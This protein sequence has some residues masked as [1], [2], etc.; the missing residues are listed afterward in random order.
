VSGESV[1]NRG[2]T[3]AQRV[4]RGPHVVF[5]FIADWWSTRYWRSL[6]WSVPALL[7][8]L[9]I[10]FGGWT[11]GRSSQ[12]DWARIY[13]AAGAAALRAGALDA[14]DVYFRRM[15][16]LDE[17]SPSAWYGLAMIAERQDDRPRARELLRRIAPGDAAGYPDAHYWLAQDLI[18]QKVPATPQA[19]R[20]LEHHLRQALRVAAH[21]GESRV[22]LAQ[23]YAASGRPENAIEELEQVVAARP[24]SQLELAR[25]YALV[26]HRP[27]AVR[28][29]SQASEF[30]QA[31]VQ[32]EPDQPQHRLCWASSLVLQ[33]RYQAAVDVLVSGLTLPDPRPLR[34]AL[35]ATYLSWF[36]ANTA[37]DRAQP[38]QRLRFLERVL[39]YDPNNARALTML[40]ELAVREEQTTDQATAILNQV[41]PKEQSPA[42]VDLILGTQA[43]HRGDGDQGLKH[44]EQALQQNPEMP[45]LMNNLAWGLAH[46][47]EPDLERA[48]Q[49]AEAAQ[50][51]SKHPETF[52][53]LG[54]I[55]IKLGRPRQAVSQLE[56]ALRVLPPRAE[57]HRKLADVYEQLGDAPLAAEHR[58]LAAR[59]DASR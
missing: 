27:E 43:L 42:M 28:A 32:Q 51:I 11:Y 13:G 3:T 19:V 41:L 45:E 18:G 38:A 54:T 48:L 49:L 44:L 9:V 29:A 6:V 55:L 36:D 25:L 34:Q 52:D 59:L 37:A 35:A 20:E 30:F 7:V 16:V 24:E 14:A 10:G 57:I 56:T 46:Q 8:G 39:Y 5:R 33:A 15:A 47:D 40:A 50:R 31:R 53:T 58:R 26:G 22:I 2:W 12:T 1:E 23:L 17:A 21:Q 4:L